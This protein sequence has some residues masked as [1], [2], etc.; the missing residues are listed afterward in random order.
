[1]LRQRLE[2]VFDTSQ[3]SSAGAVSFPAYGHWYYAPG[4]YSAASTAVGRADFITLHS[5]FSYPVFI[6]Y[7]LSRRFG[8]PYGLWPHGV[9]APVQRQVGRRK[10]MMYSPLARRILDSAAVLLFSA[11][12]ER[13]EALDCG[14]KAPSVVIPHGIEVEPFANLPERGAFRQKYLNGHSGPLILYLGRLNEKK[15][16]D[17]LVDAMKSVIREVPNAR[18]VI[19]GG[20]HPPVFADDVKR[21]LAAAG[22]TDAAILTGLVSEEE[23]LMAFADADVFALPSAAENFGFSMFEAMASGRALV[24]SDTV[25]YAGEVRA[26]KAGLVVSRSA[27]AFAE[28]IIRLLKDPGLRHALA[29]RAVALAGKYSWNSCGERL[30]IAINCVLAGERFPSSLSPA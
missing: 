17:L 28:A 12:G 29:E 14:L 21:W 18:L 4:L 25:N 8:K 19:A 7:V 13:E 26:E 23:K 1:M 16:L 20:S 11:S 24:C 2:E 22:L 6:G 30:E 10:K 5:L 15:G 9:L 3:P 27:G